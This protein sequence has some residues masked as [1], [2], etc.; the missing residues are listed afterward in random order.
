MPEEVR[1]KAENMIPSGYSSGESIYRNTTGRPLVL[2]TDSP[3]G[4]IPETS[5]DLFNESSNSVAISHL[6]TSLIDFNQLI[7]YFEITILSG[8]KGD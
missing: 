3:I 5:H 8:G 7:H 1:L 4:F 2:V 6:K